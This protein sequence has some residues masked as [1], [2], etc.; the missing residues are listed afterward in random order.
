VARVRDVLTNLATHYGEDRYRLSPLLARRH[1]SGRRL[2]DT[3]N[4]T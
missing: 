3:A 1:A 4:S 2:S